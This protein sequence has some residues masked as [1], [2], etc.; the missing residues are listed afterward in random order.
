LGAHNIGGRDPDAIALRLRRVYARATQTKWGRVALT[1]GPVA[2][3]ETLGA[4]GTLANR[5]AVPLSL[6]VALG[7]SNRQE[8]HMASIEA[9]ER[10]DAEIRDAE[11]DAL[12]ALADHLRWAGKDL[13][14]DSRLPLVFLQRA[15]RFDAFAGVRGPELWGRAG[16]DK[17]RRDVRDLDGDA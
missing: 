12:R 1:T 6:E 4:P 8:E 16:L 7:A 13:P 5:S 15:D 10:L 2:P 11:A 3:R 14:S 17:L 9:L